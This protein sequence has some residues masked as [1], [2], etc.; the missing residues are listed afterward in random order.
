MNRSRPCEPSSKPV[1]RRSTRIVHVLILALVPAVALHAQEATASRIELARDALKRWVE[2]SQCIA[3]ERG[4][5]SLGKELLSERIGLVGREIEAL[6]ARDAETQAGIAAT[7]RQ[8]D[9][10]D[11]ARTG[12]EAIA[13][14][15]EVLVVRLEAG[16]RS[17][18]PRLPEPL[19]KRIEPLAQRLPG[20]EAD[21]GT[22]AKRSLAERFQNVVGIL[23][24]TNKF[25]REITLTSEVRT[26]S[27]GSAA[28]VTT[29]YVGLGQAYWV[30][31]NGK[32]AGVG[33]PG[34]E[35]WQWRL[36]PESA[37]S[38]ANAVAIVKNER[39]AAFVQLPVEIR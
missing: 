5:W 34:T 15:L 14:D 39:V 2:A 9:E 12:S 37:S 28:E 19:R 4:D 17:L 7:S 27:D 16:L 24:E 1:A 3:K 38:I 11:A 23:N 20:D 36:V 13:R 33:V 30:G 32:L 35:G 26:L 22:A 18:L 8:R 31:A 10:L 29:M 6:R 21:R 25:D